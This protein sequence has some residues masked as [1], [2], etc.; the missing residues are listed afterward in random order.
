MNKEVKGLL[1]RS[2]GV[3]RLLKSIKKKREKESEKSVN[4]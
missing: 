2:T 3:S 4:V 1:C